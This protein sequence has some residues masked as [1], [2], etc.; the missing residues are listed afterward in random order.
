MDTRR[1]ADKLEISLVQLEK[2]S[3]PCRMGDR[4]WYLVDERS[5]RSK[6]EKTEN[7]LNLH[8]LTKG[9][10]SKAAVIA[11]SPSERVLEE[12][13]TSTWSEAVKT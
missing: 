8:K 13:A 2:F 9:K 1:L 6:D 5:R 4:E 12:R 11:A 7:S 10:K 3:W